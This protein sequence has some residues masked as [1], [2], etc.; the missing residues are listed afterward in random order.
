MA[1]GPDISP[2]DR[3]LRRIRTLSRPLTVLISIALGLVLCFL[4]LEIAF[5]VFFRQFGSPAALLSFNEW[6]INLSIGSTG[7]QSPDRAM[8]S[9]AN[10]TLGQRLTA[11][12][13]GA[14]CA[15][16]SAVVLIH[17]R[18][19]FQLYSRGIVFS[20]SNVARI[21]MFGLWLV[22]AAIV[23]NVSGRLFVWLMDAPV[24]GFAN[25]ALTIVFGAMIYVIGY[26]MEL[27]READLERKD[28]I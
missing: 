5:L 23:T 6:G 24:R 15:V 25:A 3:A 20:A 8:L 7:L 2:Q 28:F 10:L 12:G 18:G 4:T 27:G 19:L 17:L 1:T 21:R 22:V 26:V 16:C 14:L 9:V 13:L 11:A